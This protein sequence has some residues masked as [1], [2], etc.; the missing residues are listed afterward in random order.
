MVFQICKRY[1]C[2]FKPGLRKNPFYFKKTTQL[3]FSGFFKKHVFFSKKRVFCCW[4][5][6]N[7]SDSKGGPWPPRFLLGP[8]F[9]PPSFFLNLP[10][11]FIWLT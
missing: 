3:G 8:L 2:C 6:K 7:S 10:F 4:S 1:D 9:G 11:K 5:V